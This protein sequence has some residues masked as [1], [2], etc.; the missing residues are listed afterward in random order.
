MD[1]D[2]NVRTPFFKTIPA[3]TDA[4]PLKELARFGTD[5]VH[6]PIKILHPVLLILKYP[7]VEPN[8]FIGNVMRFLDRLDDADRRRFPLPKALSTIR[9]SLRCGSMSSTGVGRKN[10]DLG[11]VGLHYLCL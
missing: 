10:E 11:G 2:Y 8:K 3:K 5:L 4:S 6:D 1:A 9:D 7:I